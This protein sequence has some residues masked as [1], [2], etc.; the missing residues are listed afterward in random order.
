MNQRQIAVCD[1]I[2]A[3]EKQ[4]IMGKESDAYANVYNTKSK[5]VAYANVS[6]LLKNVNV[7]EYLRLQREKLNNRIQKKFNIDLDERYLSYQRIITNLTAISNDPNTDKRTRVAAEKAI[8]DT[9][10]SIT[11][12]AGL[13]NDKLHVVKDVEDVTKEDSQTLARIAKGEVM[14][15]QAVN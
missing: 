7:Q 3:N 6:R 8:K 5:N 11:R 9:E 15:S 14:T 10:D 13:F 4:G 12:I 1:T 2:I